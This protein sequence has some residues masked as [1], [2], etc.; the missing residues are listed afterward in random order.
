MA[1][2]TALQQY[3]LPGGLHTFLAKTEAVV[4]AETGLTWRRPF[5]LHYRSRYKYNANMK[6]RGDR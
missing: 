1:Q 3:A 4:V 2:K 6:V 5:N